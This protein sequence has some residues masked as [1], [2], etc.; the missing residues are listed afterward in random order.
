M[1][2][3]RVRPAVKLAPEWWRGDYAGLDDGRRP[4]PPPRPRKVTIRN[5]TPPPPRKP[6][7]IVDPEYIPPG[8]V[9]TAG[10]TTPPKMKLPAWAPEAAVVLGITLIGAALGAFSGRRRA[11]AP[12][13]IHLNPRD[14]AAVAKAK[15]FREEFTWGIPA[16]RVKR[17]RV[18]KAPRHLVELGKLEAVTYSTDKNGDGLS[19]YVHQFD[20]PLP[21]LAMD[22]DNKRL[23]VVGGGYTVT[24]RGIER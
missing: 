7:A 12:T 15:K 19:N 22:L 8:N 14:G 1:A 21:V 6:D 18:S 11:P 23:H 20:R 2:W 24:D 3:R 9:G 13:P 10:L 17:A 4:E 16:K 5:V